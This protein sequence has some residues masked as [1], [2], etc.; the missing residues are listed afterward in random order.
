MEW[1]VFLMFVVIS[2]ANSVKKSNKAKQKKQQRQQSRDFMHSPLEF[3]EAKERLP[4]KVSPKKEER[5]FLG[6]MANWLEDV[7]EQLDSQETTTSTKNE[8]KDSAKTIWKS[9]DTVKK[10]KSELLSLDKTDLGASKPTL[11]E[12][13]PD[14]EK[15]EAYQ[16]VSAS[17]KPLKN[18]YQ[19]QEVCEHRIELNPKIQYSG[20]K[21][22]IAMKKQIVVQTDADSL[23]QGILWSEIFGKPKAHR[24]Q[25]S[26]FYRRV[27]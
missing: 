26:L 6:K 7:T 15:K 24:P 27:R 4:K 19:N 14:R 25:E 20:Q 1:L 23:L 21:Q 5:D 11:M 18:A 17:V 2:I 12:K 8:K 10:K 13:K 3:P 22:E 9:N 16:K